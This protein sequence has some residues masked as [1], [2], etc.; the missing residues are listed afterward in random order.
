MKQ[1]NF[2]YKLIY[3]SKHVITS[4]TSLIG[5]ID[6]KLIP[7]VSANERCPLGMEKMKQNN[8]CC[9]I[10][11]DGTK[12]CWNK[13]NLETPMNSCLDP[14]LPNAYWEF[15]KSKKYYVAQHP[16]GKIPQ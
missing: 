13:C 5:T 9:S 6:Q 3:E 12:C 1:N 7:T 4:F 2:K 10:N 8:T 11:H 15:D 14:H 16:K